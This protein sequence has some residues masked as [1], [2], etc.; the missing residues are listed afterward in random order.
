MPKK[1]MCL[2]H[3]H[4][5]HFWT[6]RAICR[7]PFVAGIQYENHSHYDIIEKLVSSTAKSSHVIMVLEAKYTTFFNG[8]VFF[9]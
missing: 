9:L 2:I 3:R 5:F 8:Y 7:K 6:D 1:V 4:P